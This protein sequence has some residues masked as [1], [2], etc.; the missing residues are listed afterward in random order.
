MSAVEVIDSDAFDSMRVIVAKLKSQDGCLLS[1]RGSHDVVNWVRNFEFWSKDVQTEFPGC[2]DCT[3]HSGFKQV[4]DSAKDKVSHALG[5]V[6]CSTQTN[7]NLLYVTGHSMG[8]AVTHIAMFDLKASGWVIAKTYSF[9]APRVGNEEFAKE[10]ASHFS[11]NIP[12]FRVT[13]HK[14]VVVHVPMMNL[15]YRH[16]FAQEVFYDGNELGNYTI[17]NHTEQNYSTN[18]CADKYW[19]IP[20]MLANVHDHCNSHLVPNGEICK[21]QCSSGVVIV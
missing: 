7:Q 10:F 16:V 5:K 19:D 8:A 4:W 20:G 21:P 3:L 15:G 1:F 13:H 12:V 9:E 18:E 14:D 2:K 11:N 6:G 17:C